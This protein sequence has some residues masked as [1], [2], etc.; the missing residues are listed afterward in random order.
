MHVLLA[1]PPRRD[2]RDAGLSVPPLGLAYVAA[3]LRR[4]GITV[5]LVDAYVLGWSWARFEAHLARTRPD[6]MTVKAS[7]DVEDFAE[8]TGIRLPEGDYHTLAGFVLHQM[9]RIPQVTDHFSWN[10]L[11]FEVVDMD[12]RRVDKV[13]V[14]PLVTE[15]QPPAGEEQTV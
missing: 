14:T 5:S 7:I 11:R 10:G 13:L 3:A 8:E 15:S 9:G 6:A 1:R 4:A 12:G 2:A